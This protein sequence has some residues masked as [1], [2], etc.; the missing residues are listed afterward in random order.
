MRRKFQFSF[1]PFSSLSLLYDVCV[2]LLATVP[3]QGW[4]QKRERKEMRSERRGEEL[5]RRNPNDEPPT[6]YGEKEKEKENVNQM[7][8]EWK[9]L[10][11]SQHN[12]FQIISLCVCMCLWTVFIPKKKREEVATKRKLL[13]TQWDDDWHSRSFIFRSVRV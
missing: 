3:S 1:Y 9:F 13:H 11:L 12:L 5:R 2:F 6:K 7:K 10:S 8:Y 4:K